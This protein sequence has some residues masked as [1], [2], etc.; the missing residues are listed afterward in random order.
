MAD[1]RPYLGLN[2][3]VP[4]PPATAPL[5]GLWPGSA[6]DV[7]DREDDN[8]WE[9][10]FGF[11]P[12]TCA[13]V[14]AWHPYCAA[15][16]GAPGLGTKVETDTPAAGVSVLPFTLYVPFKC[17]TAG[18]VSRDDEGRVRRALE[19]GTS[20]GLEGEFWSDTLG[21][22]NFSLVK[23]TPNLAAGATG[24]ILN[25]GGIVPTPVTPA[26]ALALLA[27]GRADCAL[28]S[29]GMIHAPVALVVLWTALGYLKEDGPRLVTKVRGDIVVAGSGYPGTGPTG[30]SAPAAG[31]V[32]AY[33]TGLVE[34]RVSDITIL[35][36]R[37]AWAV[38]HRLN[39]IAFKAERTVAADTDGCCPQAV[40]VALS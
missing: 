11:V 18:M 3:V 16:G 12:E 21:L 30:Q 17:T 23:S 34:T 31:T 13:N 22:G 32:W 5:H 28:G 33:G 39:Q 25:P 6:R 4:P 14:Y 2:K 9:G 24:G 40:L 1:D 35:P 15:S 8:R 10:G 27:Q 36:D 19:A 26:M 20:M 29:R 38:D 37:E 7:S